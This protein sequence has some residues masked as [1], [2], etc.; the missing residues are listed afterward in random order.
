[1]ATTGTVLAK[2]MSLYVDG[3]VVTCQTNASIDM[4]TNMFSTT[5]KSSGADAAKQPGEKSWS[6]SGEANLA[7]D[8]AN[9]FSELFGAWDDQTEI[10]VIFQNG[11]T[12]DKKYSGN[13]FL[14]KL[15][16]TSNGNDEAVTFSYTLDGNGALAEATIS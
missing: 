13:A 15:T 16:L 1:M 14:S 3:T 4:Q 8:A 11:V 10:A 7:F 2:T 6:A 5:C 9:G 12:G